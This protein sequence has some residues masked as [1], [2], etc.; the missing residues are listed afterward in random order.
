MKLKNKNTGEVVEAFEGGPIDLYFYPKEHEK[1]DLVDRK[2]YQSLSKLNAEW[3]D[4]EPKEPLIKDEKIRKAVRAWAEANEISQA[5]FDRYTSGFSA[6]D[7]GHNILSMISFDGF[8]FN[9]E[10][11]KYYSIDE[12]C[13]EEKLCVV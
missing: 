9:C 2:T 13:G 12:L 10:D 4:Y 8:V 1:K 3:E 6:S 7:D 5:Q 11:G